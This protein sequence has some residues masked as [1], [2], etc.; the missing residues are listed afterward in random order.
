MNTPKIRCRCD[1]CGTKQLVKIQ[2][3]VIGTPQCYRGNGL[4]SSSDPCTG[5]LSYCSDDYEDTMLNTHALLVYLSSTRFDNNKVGEIV[6]IVSDDFGHAVE[7]PETPQQMGWV[8]Q[9]GRP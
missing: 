1:K 3:L 4:A 7:S 6:D 2:E 9:D 5:H 8:G